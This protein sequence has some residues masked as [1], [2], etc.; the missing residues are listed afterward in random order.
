MRIAIVGGSGTLGRHITAQ[1]TEHGHDVRVLSRGS[2]EFPVDLVSGSGL[3]A[4]LTGC[5]AVVDASNASAPRRAARVL[6]EGSRRLLAAEQQ[7]GVVHHVC[8]SI[9]G[10]ERAPIGYYRVK[11]EQEQVVE[12]GPVPWTIVRATQFHGLAAAALTAAGRFGVLPIPPLRLQTVAAE[13]VA[14]VAAEVAEGGPRLGRVEVA[15]PE[16]TSARDLAGTWRA[17][18][19]RRA[20]LIP[21]P[22]PG[23]LGR[24]LRDGALTTARPDAR[25]TV[26]FGAWLAAAAAAAAA[27]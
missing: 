12:H 25:G 15:G 8:I 21:V 22:V 13:E 7:A 27:G 23:R 18:T 5:A 4:A 17:V 14:A 9:V 3:P 11:A 26:T 16:I 6:V 19:G 2:P 10:C 20:L 1:L 24:A